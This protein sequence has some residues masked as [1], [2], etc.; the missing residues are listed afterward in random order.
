MRI[1]LKKNI[2]KLKSENNQLLDDYESLRRKNAA[3][4]VQVK[5]TLKKIFDSVPKNIIK[6]LDSFLDPEFRLKVFQDPST[7]VSRTSKF[8][9]TD[10]LRYQQ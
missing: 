7:T 3:L 9:D 8:G 2:N 10:K 4:Q 1:N 6:N 5:E